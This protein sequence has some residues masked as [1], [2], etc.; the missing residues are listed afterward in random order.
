MKN[1]KFCHRGT[2]ENEQHKNRTIRRFC[3]SLCALC[4]CGQFFACSKAEKKEE[5]APTPVTVET[6]STG[7]IDHVIGADALLYPI[8]Q[9][10]IVPKITAPVKRVLVNRGDH[11]KAGQLL[12]VL[13]N[14]DLAATANESKNLYDQAQAQYQSAMG[15][16]IPDD[17]TKAK[18]D[19]QSAR[20]ALEAA[21]KVYENRVRLVEEGALAQKL[22]DD[23]K[24]AMVQA[25]SAYDEAH[26][27]LEGYTSSGHPSAIAGA[28]SQ[29][30]AAK[31][32]Y[33]T[34]AAQLS[35]ADVRSPINGIVADRPVYPGEMP[36]SGSPVISIV[37]MSQ[38]V[39]RANIPVEEA[40]AIKVGRPARISAPGGDIAGKVTVVSPATTPN[41]T[42]VEVWVQCANP[43][44]RLHPGATVRVSI[45]AETIQNTV[46]VPAAALLNSE[47]GGQKVM[48]AMDNNKA[49]ERKVNVGV[50]QGD[51]VQIISGVQP[52]E[53]V[54]TSGGLGLEDKAP[55]TIQTPK[56]E[57]E[58]EPADE[59]SNPDEKGAPAKD[60]GKDAKPAEKPKP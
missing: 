44:E 19:E 45:I 27:H 17:A 47:E 30:N 10:N 16:G 36:Q 20:Q 55:I 54:I 5:E 25:Q 35:Y 60:A 22:A 48:I 26:R 56:P 3:L 21:K 42:T 32:H 24:V 13:E 1:K 52:G 14:G 49:R 31:A 51:R 38:M 37:N 33:E 12:L 11:V 41:T 9:A 7:A 59:E 57:E 40:A 39:A 28:Q 53:K 6:A 34:A 4:L 43:E 2:E 23:A 8:D 58:E 46:I 50:R 29:M 18:A 15:T